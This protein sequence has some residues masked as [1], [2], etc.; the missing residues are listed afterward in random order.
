M[1]KYVA[2]Y[3]KENNYNRILTSEEERELFINYREN[4]DLEARDKLIF[5]HIQLVNKYINFKRQFLM[6][7]T[8]EELEQQAVLIA[9]K[10]IDT[11]D[12]NKNVKFSTYLYIAL[13]TSL[14]RYI[15]NNDRTVRIPAHRHSL[16]TKI[17]KVVIEIS[18]EI[19][20]KPV[21]YEMIKERMDLSRKDYIS[22]IRDFKPI[23]SLDREIIED[24]P[25]ESKKYVDLLESPDNIEDELLR[26]ELIAE[27]N[28]AT[29][30]LDD[31]EKT[32]LDKYY[33]CNKTFNQI[34]N[35]EKVKRSALINI[36]NAALKKI[37]ASI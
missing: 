32:L 6:T 26:K 15:L 25:K 7:I 14:D 9:M 27:I 5:H 24:N 20:N 21:T 28:N 22:Y 19:G 37:R 4:N 36:K 18:T 33:F 17:M 13:Q 3:I 35:E 29:K 12:L 11:F 16:F 30:N 8:E 34:S 1:N 2:D 31:Y 23:Y 10:A